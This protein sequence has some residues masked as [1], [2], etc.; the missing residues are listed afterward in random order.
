MLW[1]IDIMHNIIGL[2]YVITILKQFSK[3]YTDNIRIIGMLV[4]IYIRVYWLV[5]GI[6]TFLDCWYNSFQH[7]NITL[8]MLSDQLYTNDTQYNL[9]GYASKETTVHNNGLLVEMFLLLLFRKNTK[10]CCEKKCRFNFLHHLKL[11]ALY[12]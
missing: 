7:N 10:L 11:I 3:W 12:S 2:C 5:Y 9:I 1:W 6:S 4:C 8:G